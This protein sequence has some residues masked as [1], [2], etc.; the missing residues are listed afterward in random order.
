LEV[1][2]AI[3]RVPAANMSVDS[4]IDAAIINAPMIEGNLG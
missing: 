1:S 2:T 3:N 4:R